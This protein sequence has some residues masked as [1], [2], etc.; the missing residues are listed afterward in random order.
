MKKLL[1]ILTAVFLLTGNAAVY[2][3]ETPTTAVTS[4]S[5]YT[6]VHD[7][8]DDPEAAKD[9]IRNPDAVYGYSPSPEST[10]LKEYAKY[11][12]TDEEFV[13]KSRQDR[14]DYHKAKEQI[15]ILTNKLVEEGKSI[16]EIARAASALRNQIR[17][18]SYKDN[19]EGLA[20]VKKSNLETYGNEE[21]PTADSL[22]EEYGSWT[23]V[24]EK[25][26]SINKGMDACLG[27]YDEMYSVYEALET[28]ANEMKL[29]AIPT[30][31]EPAPAE[32]IVKTGDSLWFLSLKYYDDG[33]RWHEIYQN[34]L[35]LIR[36][37]SEIYP[38]MKL[39]M[40]A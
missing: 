8:M 15:Y 35:D 11:D 27:L 19:P 39:R 23:T 18:D 32:Y 25:A 10:R 36:N 9:I 28:A 6:Y 16:E 24:L 4:K 2:A 33:N 5:G 20:T 17:L 37:P 34:N 12:W 13:A 1:A 3:E 22:Y 26:F 7:P 31:V 38:G 21:G 29:P 14:I 30:G 40:P